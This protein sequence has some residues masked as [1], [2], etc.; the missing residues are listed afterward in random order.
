M[1]DGGGLEVTTLGSTLLNG[2][3][4]G[5][6]SSALVVVVVVVVVAVNPVDR[7]AV[8]TV[9]FRRPKSTAACRIVA[10]GATV[11]A[12]ITTRPVTVAAGGVGGG[13]AAAARALEQSAEDLFTYASIGWALANATPFVGV[14]PLVGGSLLTPALQSRAGT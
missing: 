8:D 6:S 2:S 7:T 4:N 10:A 12:G 3:V 9:S 13:G 1:N 5:L 14:P 11:V